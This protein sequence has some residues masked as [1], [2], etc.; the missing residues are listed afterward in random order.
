MKWPSCKG[1]FISSHNITLKLVFKDLLDLGYIKDNVNI[2]SR[3]R[4]AK[5]SNHFIYIGIIVL[6]RCYFTQTLKISFNFLYIFGN[7]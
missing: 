4:G 6:L 7:P 3:Q 5:T 2:T 1:R